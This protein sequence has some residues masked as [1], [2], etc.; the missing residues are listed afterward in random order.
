MNIHYTTEPPKDF[1]KFL[2]LY[3][4]LGWNSLNL[5][6]NELKQMCNQS[7]YVIYA[8]DNE[9]LVGTGRVISDGVITGTICGV[10]VIPSYQ[11]KGIGKEIM[12]RIVHHCEE[13]RVIPQLLC[14]E[15]LES[16]YESLGFKKFTIGMKKDI[17]R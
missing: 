12:K 3:E 17:N 2:N 14:E 16:Y 7:W 5:T 1:V 15:R 11:S 8:F 4:A 10:S 13:N 9:E 6:V